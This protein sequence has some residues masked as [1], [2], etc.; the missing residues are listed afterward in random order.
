MEIFSIIAAFILVIACINF[1]NLSTARASRRLKEIGVKKSMGVSRFSLGIQFVFEAFLLSL[2]ALVVALIGV[3]FFLPIFNQ[4]VDKNLTLN[5]DVQFLTFS[6]LVLAISTF[7]AGSYP[8]FYLSGFKPIQV[9]KGKMTNSLSDLWI[10]KGLV[11][12]QFC[13]TALLIS[14]VMVISSQ[15]DYV[16]NKNLGY[17]R[18]QVI[19][20]NADGNLD[21]NSATF[22]HELK[23][24]P[25]IENAALFGHDLLGDKGMTTG[26]S[27]DGKDPES[28]IR[29]ANL[30]IGVGLIETFGIELL[31][32]RT[33]S[34]E[35]GDET[36]KIILNEKAIEV[37]ELEDPIG[38]TIKLW[39]RDR[40][41][42]RGGQKLPPGVSSRRNPSVLH[43][44]LS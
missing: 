15:I 14:S 4:I 35:F 27:W 17:D 7:L 13:T 40:E 32:G 25:G 38:K 42:I 37:M 19:Q 16:M 43:A 5:F 1:M 9:L 22:I 10:R 11:I 34:D 18:E 36:S 41:I 30:E 24:I 23:S 44:V 39:R 8:A 26:L 12:F 29:F 21:D 2:F 31:E 3:Q 28:K 33:Y 20:F 6:G